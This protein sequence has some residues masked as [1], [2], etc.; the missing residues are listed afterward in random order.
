MICWRIIALA[1]AAVI[2]MYCQSPPAPNA[3]IPDWVLYSGLF[4]EVW[5]Q[6][7]FAGDEDAKG[8]NSSFVRSHIRKAAGLTDDEDAALKRIAKDWDAAH[9][10]YLA[11][12]T[13]LMASLR[14]SAAG[15]KADPNI[16]HS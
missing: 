9:R 14:A 3:S 12:R 16:W 5:L 2:A 8:K 13:K 6:E 15:G 10:A 7:K 4:K 11:Q 1:L